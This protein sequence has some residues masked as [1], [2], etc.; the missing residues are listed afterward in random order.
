MILFEYINKQYLYNFQTADTLFLSGAEHAS[1]TILS[2]HK[3]NQR[4]VTT[5]RTF[6]GPFAADLNVYSG[7]F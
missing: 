1:N 2:L 6:C 7:E 5:A 3:G 4:D